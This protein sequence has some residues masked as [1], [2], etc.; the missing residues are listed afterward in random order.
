V[1]AVQSVRPRDGK[2]HPGKKLITP[3]YKEKV[4]GSTSSSSMDSEEENGKLRYITI[5]FHK[6][7][8][9]ALVDSGC[10]VNVIE[11]SLYE[12]LPSNVKTRINRNNQ[13]LVKVADNSIVRCCG[14]AKVFASFQG[15]Q[16]SL[17]VLV[18]EN[19]SNPLILGTSFLTAVGAKLDFSKN[20]MEITKVKSRSCR[21]TELP[22]KS[23]SVISIKVPPSVPLG[24]NG[25]SVG[26]PALENR[27]I[28][29]AKS[30]AYVSAD[31]TIPVK[32]LNPGNSP[33][34]LK[35]NF[36]IASFQL[37]DTSYIVTPMFT[38]T[39]QA[40]DNQI[41]HISSIP[42]QNRQKA[43]FLQNFNLS[44][45]DHLES[46]QKQQIEHMLWSYSDIFV[47][48][49]NPEIGLTPLVE[50]KIHITQ[51]TKLPHQR[52]YRLSPEKKVVLRHQLEELVKRGVIVPVGDH[53]ELP[54]TSPIVLVSKPKA[55]STAGQSV[56]EASLAQWRFCTD[57]RALNKA[58]ADSHYNIPDLQ[59]LV[60]SFSEQKP[61]FIT[62]LDLSHGFHQIAVE[63]DST[64]YTAFNTCFGTYKY[65]RLPMGLKTSPNTMQLLMD[66]VLKGLTFKSCLSY[67]DDLLIAS[68]TFE[69][70][71]EEVSE[72]FNRLREANLKIGPMKCSF[73]QSQCTFLGH[74]V[75]SNGIRPPK[76]RLDKIKHLQPPRNIRELR[77]ILGLFN[78]FRKFIP[79][80]STAAAPLTKLMRKN[81]QFE[82][83]TEQQEAFDTLKQRLLTSDILAFPRYDIPFKLAVDT[84]CEGTGYMLYQIHPE[85]EYPPGTPEKERSRVIRFGSRALTRWQRSYGPTKLE[86]LGVLQ[87]VLDCAP[88]VRGR[89]FYIECDHQALKPLLQKKLRGKLYERWLSIL[90]QFNIQFEYKPAAQM[91]VPD[92]LSRSK[93]VF[94]PSV[95][96]PDEADPNFPYTAEQSGDVKLPGG[97]DLQDLILSP[98]AN[99][100]HL[101]QASLYDGDTEDSDRD[102][103]DKIH[104]A[105]NTD[106]PTEQ[107]ASMVSNSE[108]ETPVELIDK[109]LEAIELLNTS[110]Y[111]RATL[112]KLQSSDP[113]LIPL[114]QYLKT[115]K[116]PRSQKLARSVLLKSG[117]YMLIN[118]LLYHSRKAKSK[119]AQGQGS[120]QVVLPQVIQPTM[121]KLY[122]E[123]PLAGHGGIK[124]TIDRLKEHYFFDKLA[125]KVSDYVQSCHEC[126]TR[127]ITKAH[128]KSA[129]VAYPTPSD[130]FQ[131]WQIDIFGELPQTNS[132]HKYVFTAVCMFSKFLVCIPIQNKDTLTVA[133]ALMQ[134]ISLYG[135]P[136]T[137]VSDKGSEFMS[138]AFGEVCKS[139]HIP[140]QFTPSFA[141]HC[142]GACER[143]H[144]TLAQRLTPYMDTQNWLQMLPPIVFS[145]NNTVNS[146]LGY[147]PHEIVF[148][149]RP[150]FPLAPDSLASDLSTVPANSHHYIKS[151]HKRLQVIRDEITATAEKAKVRML[152]RANSK[153]NPLALSPGDYVYM[154]S[155]PTGKGAKLKPTH[156]GPYIVMEQTSPHM[157]RLKDAMSQKHLKHAVHIDRLKMAYVREPDPAPYFPKPIQVS[158]SSKVNV[159]TQ[160]GSGPEAIPTH[161]P[162]TP[163]VDDQSEP[164]QSHQPPRRSTRTSKPPQRFGV[165]IELSHSSLSSDS[166]GYHK[167]KRILGVRQR[168]NQTQYLVQ[169]RG[170]SAQQSIWVT[171]NQMD[172]KARSRALSHPLI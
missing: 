102:T 82:W 117:D 50:H 79:N 110:G 147:S 169:I 93:E 68:S 144:N 100:M 69:S 157:V 85:N 9:A 11:R 141:H 59:E 138:R 167:I 162:E 113:S 103:G 2:V 12:K 51:N 95:S 81:R 44:N 39:G 142:L 31:H 1:R 128:T 4:A 21:D 90:Q 124:D 107:T 123:C 132:G 30:I 114:I 5:F 25:I 136:T 161:D 7:R 38:N 104:P 98:E 42:S 166:D 134:L 139:L 109:Q 118:G 54:I 29:M 37:L 105:S 77:R 41:N 111:D 143:T 80:F 32:L 34:S 28:I 13:V 172:N 27:G 126:Q 22:P 171:L 46:N 133:D 40:T 65:L 53:E 99:H 78:W 58:T 18:M 23:E 61:E 43:T 160:T 71:V 15:C 130:K 66:R 10:N 47:T 101:E 153:T 89:L 168:G 148:G 127:K 14:S 86:L 8:V 74:E 92:A 73:A 159:S 70:H 17:E 131:V 52:P 164:V 135:C 75:S 60:E 76:D 156:T 19:T 26:T 49:E 121:I 120:Y 106:S 112:I 155:E 154:Q 20:T 24:A 64:K 63:K 16:K 36:P 45:L 88:Y 163:S 149:Q 158:K 122:H 108:S 72:V 83:F 67:L 145:I 3:S 62:T 140:Q 84:S 150:R 91:V 35:K 151:H 96:S 125:P 33:V 129:I 116:L 97:I 119:R 6:T 115:S 146:S 170:E 94:D 56:K 57:F 152:D 87:A 55:K 137:I 165:P 48:A